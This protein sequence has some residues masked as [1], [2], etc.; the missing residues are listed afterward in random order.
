MIRSAIGLGQTTGTVIADR[1]EARD[2]VGLPAAAN[3][4]KPPRSWS[5][6]C[7]REL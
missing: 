2:T 3:A 7:Q 6:L 1:E 5:Q 4:A